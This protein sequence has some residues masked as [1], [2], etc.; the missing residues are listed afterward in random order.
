M[1]VITNMPIYQAAAVASAL[2]LYA[3]TGMKVN[4]AYTPTNMLKMAS[5]ITGRTFKRTELTKAAD[6]LVAWIDQRRA[7]GETLTTAR[8]CVTI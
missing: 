4:R 7:E 2:R 1:T 6:S 3:E 8:P 5:A